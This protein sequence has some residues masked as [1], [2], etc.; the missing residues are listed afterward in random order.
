MNSIF[1][2]QPRKRW[3]RDYNFSADFEKLNEHE[4]HVC[5]LFKNMNLV[6][7]NI[8]K[9]QKWWEKFFQA[10]NLKKHDLIFCKL[11]KTQKYMD[12]FKSFKTLKEHPFTCLQAEKKAQKS[13]I[14]FF[15][16]LKTSKN[17]TFIF[18]E[19]KKP[20]KHEFHENVFLWYCLV[21]SIDTRVLYDLHYTI[22][23]Q[24]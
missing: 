3:K 4:F 9:A 1:F 13:W 12:F 20:Q 23:L 16:S 18:C 15:A 17:M 11:K 14:S 5:K 6:L 7:C 10:K 2:F 22:Q 19:L 24:G 21:N 8:K